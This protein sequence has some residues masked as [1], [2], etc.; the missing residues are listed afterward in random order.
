MPIVILSGAGCAA[1]TA[2]STIRLKPE[3]RSLKP[4]V[5]IDPPLRV[6]PLLQIARRHAASLRAQPR[7]VRFLRLAHHLVHDAEIDERLGRI[8]LHRLELVELVPA[9]RERCTIERNATFLIRA[10]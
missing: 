10:R 7:V 5:A 3:A 1:A 4:L 9:E 8:A 6:D 2:A